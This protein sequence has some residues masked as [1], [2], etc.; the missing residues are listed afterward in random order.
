[1]RVLGIS[2]SLRRDS[3]NS[4]LLRAAAER[5]PAG[6]ELVPFER[7]AEIP[8]YDEDAELA[9]VPAV[10]RDLREAIRGA[11]AVLVAT[12]EYNHSLPGQLKNALDW[13][14]RPAGKSALSGKPAAAIG[15][16]TGMFGAV[17]ASRGAQGAR[18]ARRPRNRV[19]PPDR[20]RGR[21]APR[22]PPRA[23]TRAGRALGGDP[24]R[25]GR[26]RR[27]RARRGL[28]STRAVA[29][30]PPLNLSSSRS[31]RR[32]PKATPPAA[33]RARKIGNWITPSNVMVGS[34]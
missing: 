4:A 9:T 25:A 34:T 19:R 6:A 33:A 32:P 22:R 1:M 24:C 8:P 7:L 17:G 30:Q 10:V 13:A 31:A 15:A 16:S 21:A 28:R 12:P 2:G 14:S 20:P 18:R 11:D 29:G 3:H 5:L 27:A 23:G 26:C